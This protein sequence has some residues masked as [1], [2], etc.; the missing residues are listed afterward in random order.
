LPKTTHFAIPRPLQ[1]VCVPAP[2]TRYLKGLLILMIIAGGCSAPD[3]PRAG[4]PDDQAQLQA[5]LQRL[6]TVK[7]V[8]PWK[9]PAFVPAAD[10]EGLTIDTAHY[11]IHTAVT[12]PLV[13]QQLSFFLESA[14]RAY[15]QTAGAAHKQHPLVVYLFA[16]RDQWEAFTRYWTGPQAEMYLKITAGA[17]YARGAC[18][19]Y[20]LSRQANF[21]V[22][23]HEGWHQFS[24]AMFVYRLPAWLDEGLATMFEAYRWQNGQLA[25]LPRYNANRLLALRRT[26][27][28]GRWYPL[29]DLLRLDAG[30]VMAYAQEAAPIDTQHLS[31]ADYYAQLYA[32]VR[33]L[34][35]ERY[36]RRLAAFHRMLA[37]GRAGRW[38]LEESLAAEAR[39][40]DHSPSR[41]WNAIVGP[42]LFQTYIAATPEELEADYRRFC[43]RLVAGIRFKKRL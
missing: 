19:A 39:Q 1:V 3:K 42:L 37:D 17:Y 20:H 40:R 13:V 5:R 36:G 10:T 7:R 30:R 32:L 23:A 21:S 34:R 38:P 31:A 2:G 25:F 29:K 4:V 18:V 35:E 41:R 8:T 15:E 12:D 26:V 43:R 24:D 11:R 9:L 16:G 28:Q 6:P 33:F 27:V 14:F 22:L